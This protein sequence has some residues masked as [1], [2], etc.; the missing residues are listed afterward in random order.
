MLLMKAFL[1]L[2]FSRVVRNNSRGNNS[3][4]WKFSF[5]ILNVVP[6]LFFAADFNLFSYALVSLTLDSS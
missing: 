1:I 4:T 5:I 6:V 2:V 3:S